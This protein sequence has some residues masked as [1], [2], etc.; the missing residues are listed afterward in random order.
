M[1]RRLPPPAPREP[2]VREDIEHQHEREGDPEPARRVEVEGCARRV[3]DEADAPLRG[4]AARTSADSS[5]VFARPA[6]SLPKP[7]FSTVKA[8]ILVAAPR[9]Y[10]DHQT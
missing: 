9:P 5:A 10:N 6:S 2:N 8:R 4:K 7:S 1:L 3:H